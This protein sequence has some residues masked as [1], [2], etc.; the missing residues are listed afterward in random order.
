MDRSKLADISEI[1]SSIAIVI[2]L[3][4]LIIESSQNTAAIRSQTAQAILQAGQTDLAMI[5]ADPEIGM[6]IPDTGTLTPEQNVRLDAHFVMTM[7][8]REFA[9]LQYQNGS[10]DANNFEGEVQ[11]LHVLLD[12]IRLRAWWEK[13][14]RSYMTKEFAAFVDQLIAEG[15]A[16]DR[17][18]L[19]TLD[20]SSARPSTPEATSTTETPA[21]S[22]AD[23]QIE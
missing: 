4:Y 19:P 22:Q 16:T 18:W 20:W 21:Q 13:L 12:S 9:W 3:I 1:V 23:Q 6:T 11:V 14:G 10:I 2:T 8:S 17:L 15:P 7:R 5:V